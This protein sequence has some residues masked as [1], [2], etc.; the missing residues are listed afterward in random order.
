M[1]VARNLGKTLR[2]FQPTIKELQEV[3][4]EFKSTLEREIG[5]DD[6]ST[7]NTYSSSRPDATSTPSSTTST[8]DSQTVVDPKMANTSAY[9]DACCFILET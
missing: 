8:E 9:C 1:Q 4:R 5:L 6:I 3:S 2:T 7:P